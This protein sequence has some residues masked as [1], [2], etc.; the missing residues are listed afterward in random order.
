MRC[1]LDPLDCGS[2]HIAQAL[3]L[4]CTG[5]GQWSGNC[6]KCHFKMTFAVGTKGARFVWTCW[7]Q[8]ARGGLSKC[9]DADIVAAM[10]ALGVQRDCVRP[11]G[12]HR[13]PGESAELKRLIDYVT[14][15]N[16]PASALRLGV[17]IDTGMPAEEARQRLGLA[18][19]TYYR[20][21]NLISTRR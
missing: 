18:K 10:E 8:P 7:R 17:L 14:D 9:S 11:A 12:R 4:R 1:S 15:A 16:L 6:P 13:K 20:A 2:D 21:L 5:P 19:T 3:G